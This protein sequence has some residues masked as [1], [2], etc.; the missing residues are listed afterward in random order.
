MKDPN[1]FKNSK[2]QKILIAHQNN[3]GERKI[4][5]IREYGGSLFSLD[6]FSIDEELPMIIDDANEYLPSDIKSDLVLDFLGHPD[7]SHDLAKLCERLKIPI[8][9]SGKKLKSK[10]AITPPT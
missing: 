1:K 4:E 7:I 10:W 6:S 9:S 5:G 8:I 3:S 2:P